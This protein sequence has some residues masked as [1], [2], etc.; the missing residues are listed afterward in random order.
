M[1]LQFDALL[2]EGERIDVEKVDFGSW[3]H[4]RA[5]G[6]AALYYSAG[7]QIRLGLSVSDLPEKT[8]DPTF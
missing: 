3:R 2:H 4:R 5:G 8:P 1:I 6:G 7:L